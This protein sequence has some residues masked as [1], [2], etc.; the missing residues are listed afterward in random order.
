MQPVKMEV[1]TC[2]RQVPGARAEMLGATVRVH[3]AMLGEPEA[4]TLRTALDPF[5]AQGAEESGNSREL[6]G[7]PE[8]DRH[9]KHRYR[10]IHRDLLIAVRVRYGS[11]VAL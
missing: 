4:P 9:H 10:Q 11:S 6:D 1:R 7:E 3:R 5:T 8:E 2:S